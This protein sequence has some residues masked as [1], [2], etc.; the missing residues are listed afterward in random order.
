M[1]LNDITNIYN[2]TKS[3]MI[4]VVYLLSTVRTNVFYQNFELVLF[5]KLGALVGTLD[6]FEQII[7]LSSTSEDTF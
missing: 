7:K 6:S 3:S 4:C 1:K 5:Q 2:R